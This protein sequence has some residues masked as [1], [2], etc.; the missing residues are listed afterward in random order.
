MRKATVLLGVLW[1][2]LALA[3]ATEGQQRDVTNQP[4]SAPH[5]DPTR[6]VPLEEQHRAPGDTGRATDPAHSAAP[7]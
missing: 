6:Q 7:I 5:G 3:A 4:E 1:S 2:A